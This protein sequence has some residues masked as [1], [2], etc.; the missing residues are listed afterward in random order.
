MAII[1]VL[2]GVIDESLADIQ[3]YGF[4]T[5]QKEGGCKMG[6]WSYSRRPNG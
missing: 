1:L 3:L 6:L 5:R 4:K 2:V